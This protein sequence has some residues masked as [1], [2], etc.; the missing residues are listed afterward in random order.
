[1]DR[2]DDQDRLSILEKV[3]RGEISIEEAETVLNEVLEK[4]ETIIVQEEEKVEEAPLG[5]AP[6][7][8]GGTRKKKENTTNMDLEETNIPT[9]RER[10]LALAE[11]FRNWEP[12]MMIGSLES[13]GGF[14]QWPWENKNWQWMWQDFDHPIYVAHSAEVSE[15]C[16][17]QMVSYQGDLFIRGWDEPMLKING[18]VFDLRIAQEE[19]IIRIASCTG[20][21][22][23]W[24]P[25]NIARVEATVKP[26]DMW[27]SNIAADIDVYCQSGDLGCERIKGN[28]KV[29]VNGGDVRLTGIA[30]SISAD[31]TNGNCE[32]RDI[33]S[34]DV[35]LKAA[36]GDIWLGLGS[37]TDGRFKCDNED[38]DINLL[39]DGE[40]AGE[41][42]AEAI[43]GGRIAPVSLPW[44]KLLGRSEN[45]LHG[46]LKDGGA[47]IN[48]L[49][50]SGRIYIQESWKNTF[51]ES[52]I[53]GQREISKS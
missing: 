38:G 18:A 51:P 43:G 16:K 32:L 28:V 33:S 46:I 15:N 52:K 47:S 48:L 22:Q 45:K 17:L 24:L 49:T 20:Q 50:Q 8:A 12:N 4:D 35:A 10:K 26:G 27:L 40:L 13:E 3:E 9:R 14:W 5:S 23:I 36:G 41:I 6:A 34:T 7:Y 30:G 31:V 44:Q 25:D 2:N 53:P 1:M 39:I 11:R 37:V 29:R 42:I 21:L 19:E